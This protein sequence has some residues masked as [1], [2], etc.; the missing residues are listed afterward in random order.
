M[1]CIR[2][3]RARGEGGGRRRPALMQQVLTRLLAHSAYEST[4]LAEH[5]LKVVLHTDFP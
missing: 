2:V 4:N 5:S 3:S 1:K